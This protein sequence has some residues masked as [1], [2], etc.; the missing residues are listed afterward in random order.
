L[1][2]FPSKEIVN[3]YES[4]NLKAFQSFSSIKRV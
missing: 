3:M 2:V 4:K 1:H